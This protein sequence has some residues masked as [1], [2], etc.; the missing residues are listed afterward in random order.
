MVCRLDPDSFTSWYTTDIP[1]TEDG[2]VYIQLGRYNSS[3]S[4]SLFADHPAYWFKDGAFRPYLTRG[5]TPTTDKPR[6]ALFNAACDTAGGVSVKDLTELP[7]DYEPARGDMIT[8]RFA[9]GNSAANC[10]FTITGRVVQYQIKF[11]G[12]ATNT[13]SSAWKPGG[14]FQF[15]FDGTDFHQL[16]YAN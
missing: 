9:N 15:F 13:T 10:A 1:T 7:G 14:V 2:K 6:P 4:F 5:E 16:S 8:V 12:L 11:N 3:T